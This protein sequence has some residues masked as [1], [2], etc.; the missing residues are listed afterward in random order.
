MDDAA[1]KLA[2]PKFG[3]W[4][5]IG[6]FDN[7]GMKGFNTVYPPEKGIDLKTPDGNVTRYSLYLY[8]TGPRP[9]DRCEIVFLPKSKCILSLRSV[10]GE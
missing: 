10:Q 5:Y 9:G 7:T 8:L 3:P 1:I 4:H 2:T 6:P